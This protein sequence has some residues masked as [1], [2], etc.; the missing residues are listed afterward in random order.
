VDTFKLIKAFSTAGTQKFRAQGKRTHTA[1]QD[2]DLI[3]AQGF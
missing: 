3:M 1:I 2:E